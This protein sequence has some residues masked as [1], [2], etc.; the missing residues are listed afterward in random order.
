MLSELTLAF[1]ALLLVLLNGFFVLAEFA[2]VKVRATRLEAL[3]EKGVRDARLAREILGKLDAYLSA[4]QIGITIASLA[5]GWIG[6]PAFAR[7]FERFL[8]L[9]GWLSSAVSHGSALTVAFFFIT[10]LHILIGELVP[11]SIAIQHADAAALFSARPLHLFYRLFAIPLFIMNG[12]SRA[13]LRLLRVPPASEA[14]VTYTEEELRSILG[15]SQERGGFSFHHL[16]LLENAF[17]F[18]DLRVKDV[19]IPLKNITF[20]DPSRPW[21]DNVA[22]ITEKRFSRYPLREGPRGSI[23]G[24]IHVKTIALDLLAGKTPDLRRENYKLLRISEDVLLE[25]ALHKLQ[26]AGEHMGVVLSSAGAEI[27]ILTF[28]HIVEELIGDVRDEFEPS[29]TISI[30]KILRPETV[31]LDPDVR[32]RTEIIEFLVQKAC[33]GADGLDPEAVLDAIL[34]REKAVPAS[35][36]GGIAVPHARVRGLKEPRAAFARIRSGIEYQAPDG[37]PVHLVLLIL[38]PADAAPGTQ[39]R[40]LRRT[41]GL[42]QSDYVRARLLDAASVDEVLEIFRI[43]ETSASV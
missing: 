28:E 35:I 33:G 26:N 27:G 39:A 30:S 4:T 10:F 21:P 37:R 38:T 16:L 1:I 2:I 31:V 12:A 5:L 17:D 18:G 9:P 15:A 11:K 19:A 43:G 34:K 8:E 32:D 6:E 23:L 22:V 14:E 29:R 25:V 36:S 42:M 40:A 41:A 13:L 20:L 3:A 7:L 24:F